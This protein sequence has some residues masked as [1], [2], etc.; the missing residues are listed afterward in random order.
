MTK[1]FSTLEY[2]I[3][4][5][6][7]VVRRVESLPLPFHFGGAPRRGRNSAFEPREAQRQALC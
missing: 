7:P 4:A 6:A 3:S 1:P 2:L 5:L